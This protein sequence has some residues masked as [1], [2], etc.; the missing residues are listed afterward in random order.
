MV[1]R[2]RMTNDAAGLSMWEWN[3]KGDITRIDESSPFIERLGKPQELQRAPTT[4]P[5]TCIR[6]IARAGW[7]SSRRV[8][9]SKDQMFSHR[10]RAIF[11]EGSR[12]YPVSRPRSAQCQGPAGERARHRLGR[13]RRGAGEGGDRAP[14][15]RPARSAGAL[16]ARRLG[17]ATRSARR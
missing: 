12:L 1:E 15:G 16:P 9:T 6:T 3:I 10:Y 8:L 2:I 17:H 7:S 5:S 13:D 4:P 11:A 14:V